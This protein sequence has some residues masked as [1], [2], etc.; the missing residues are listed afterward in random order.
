MLYTGFAAG[1]YRQGGTAGSDFICLH[2]TPQWGDVVRALSNSASM[3]GVE[4][5]F[6]NDDPFSKVN[7]GGQNLGNHNMPCSACHVT[8]RSHQLMIPGRK[9]CPSG[10]TMEYWGYLVASSYAH[11]GG[12]YQCLDQAPESA[13]GGAH[14]QSY[15]QYVYAAEIH[16]GGLPCSPFFEGYEISCVVCSK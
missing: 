13:I 7:V 6:R 4:Y 1:K 8:T 14:A 15:L 11:Q 3:S 10:W 12:S 2:G 9:S 16:C 5:T